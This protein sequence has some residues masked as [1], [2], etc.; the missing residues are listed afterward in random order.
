MSLRDPNDDYDELVPE[1]KNIL[2]KA[3]GKSKMLILILI[4]GVVL[5][6][7]LQYYYI[8]PAIGAMQ[9]DTCRSC[10]TSKSLLTQE[11]ECLYTLISE[12]KSV[13]EKCAANAFNEQQTAKDYNEEPAE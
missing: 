3:F 13:S 11:N 10:F 4:V 8:D 9:T 7:L 5:G 6:A 1:G 12:P 2:G